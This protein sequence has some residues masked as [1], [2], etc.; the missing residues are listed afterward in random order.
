MQ[1]I[2]NEIKKWI[3]QCNE[4]E[5][6]LI[7]DLKREDPKGGWKYV[8]PSVGMSW[9]GEKLLITSSSLNQ[10]AGAFDEFPENYQ[11]EEVSFL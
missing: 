10:V 7:K 5:R 1:K 6:V 3:Q 9:N 8:R 11:Y 4:D 2:P